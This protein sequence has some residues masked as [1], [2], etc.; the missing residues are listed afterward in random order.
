MALVAMDSRPPSFPPSASPSFP[1]SASPSFPPSPLRLSPHA[2]SLLP[3]EPNLIRGGREGEPFPSSPPHSRGR[4]G[5]REGGREVLLKSGD[6]VVGMMRADEG[7]TGKTGGREEGK[8]GGN[9]MNRSGGGVPF[10]ALS[11]YA[12]VS[13]WHVGGSG[14]I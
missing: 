12:G 14:G 6:G 11:G 9:E 3:R 2:A 7:E 10:L 1:P 8:D 5:G 13:I 4:E